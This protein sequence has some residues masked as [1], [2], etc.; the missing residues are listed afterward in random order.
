MLRARSSNDEGVVIIWLLS[1][2]WTQNSYHVTTSHVLPRLMECK[3]FSAK[4]KNLNLFKEKYTRCF[5]FFVWKKKTVR[6]RQI[7]LVIL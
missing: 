4:K 2:L 5:S 1:G 6:I 3:I 7:N